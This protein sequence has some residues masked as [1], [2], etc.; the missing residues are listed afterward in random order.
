MAISDIVALAPV[1]EKMR[2][3]VALY[4]ACAGGAALVDEV[5]QMLREAGFSNIRVE[6]KPKSREMIR[7]YFPGSGLENY[8]ASATIEASKPDVK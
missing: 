5:K 1:P 6:P 7:D 2:K 8:F 3:D 4:T